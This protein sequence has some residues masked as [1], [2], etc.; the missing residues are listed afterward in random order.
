[1]QQPNPWILL[2]GGGALINVGMMINGL[3]APAWLRHGGLVL[4]VIMGI[5]SIGLAIART[6]KKKPE[7][8]RYAPRKARRVELSPEMRGQRSAN[9]DEPPPAA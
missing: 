6:R 3:H 9:D 8:P 4:C 1:M 2:M 7:P 5:A